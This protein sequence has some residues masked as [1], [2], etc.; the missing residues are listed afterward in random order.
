MDAL[1]PPG[2]VP[3]GTL[4]GSLKVMWGCCCVNSICRHAHLPEPPGRSGPV[5]PHA[6]P[7][8]T[9]TTR[10]LPVQFLRFGE[11]LKLS[12][13][14]GGLMFIH[15]PRVAGPVGEPGLLD[16]LLQSSTCVSD[17]SVVGA[18]DADRLPAF[19]NSAVSPETSLDAKD[20]KHKLPELVIAG[21]FLH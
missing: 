18:A 16:C 10:K 12:D 5:I 9:P 1:R 19:V 2:T 8:A 11:Q 14:C 13:R 3:S 20:K 21:P 4:L 15:A 7:H 6:G 17:H